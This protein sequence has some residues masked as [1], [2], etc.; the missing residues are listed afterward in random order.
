VI[1]RVVSDRD[2]T[3]LAR[4]AGHSPTVMRKRVSRGLRRLRSTTRMEGT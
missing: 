4:E 1:E 2:Y 3:E